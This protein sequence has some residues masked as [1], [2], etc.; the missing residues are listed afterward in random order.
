MRISLLKELG[1]NLFK[2]MFGGIVVAF[3]LIIIVGITTRYYHYNDNSSALIR[4]GYSL[5][6]EDLIDEIN[7]TRIGDKFMV[8]NSD[9]TDFKAKYNQSRFLADINDNKDKIIEGLN[10]NSIR[11]QLKEDFIRIKYKMVD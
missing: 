10:T 1:A 7:W 6:K 3:I 2:Y 4:Y 9:Y 11:V 5:Y 8:K